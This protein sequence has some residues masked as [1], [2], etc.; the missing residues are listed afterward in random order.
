[1]TRIHTHPTKEDLDE[2]AAREVAQ[3]LSGAQGERGIASIALAGGSSPKAVYHLLAEPPLSEQ[4]DWKKVEVFFGD[5]R[6]VPADAP[7]SNFLMAHET[8]LAR[9]CPPTEHVHAVQGELPPETAAAQYE[10]EIREVLGESPRFDLVLLGMGA[11][12]HTASLFPSTPDLDGGGRLVIATESPKP[13]TNRI[14]L[15]LPAINNARHVLFLVSG[16][17]KSDALARVW[18]GEEA[19]PASHVQPREGELVW[20]VDEEANP[21]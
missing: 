17:E 7:D 1:M 19:L 3:I 13:P 4:V 9:V 12:G 5:E 10:E 20:H 18:D 6:C 16:E 15:T 11:D 21:S 8:L 14:T 2:A